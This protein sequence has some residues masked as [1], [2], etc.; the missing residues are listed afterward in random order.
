MLLNLIFYANHVGLKA[1]HQSQTSHSFFQFVSQFDSP[2]NSHIN[3]FP[4]QKDNF[5]S[6][7]RNTIVIKGKLPLDLV[8]IANYATD[9]QATPQKATYPIRILILDDNSVRLEGSLFSDHPIELYVN[10]DVTIFIAN[11]AGGR[12]DVNQ[13]QIHAN[14]YYTGN[15]INASSIRPANRSG[16]WQQL[17]KAEFAARVDYIINEEGG[18]ES[19]CCGVPTCQCYDKSHSGTCDMEECDYDGEYGYIP[20]GRFIQGV[21]SWVEEPIRLKTTP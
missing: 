13:R 11:N 18:G 15:M 14:I 17:S 12:P 1:F 5:V 20:L 4:V 9:N 3:P 8:R 6:D 19:K 21:K 2:S 16:N 7:Y 10:G